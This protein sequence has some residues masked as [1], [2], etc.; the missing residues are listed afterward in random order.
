[1]NLDRR[2]ISHELHVHLYGCLTPQDVWELGRDL[3]RQRHERLNAYA[4]RYEG[5]FGIR[6]DFESYWA[7]ELGLANI[8][9]DFLCTTP[10]S[11]EQFETKFSLPIA[12]FPV[13]HARDD[14][15]VL[16]HVMERHRS[17]GLVH[18]EYRFVYPPATPLTLGYSLK[19]HLD[20]LCQVMAEFKAESCGIFESRLALSL[21]RVP[22]LGMR[23]YLA[24]KAWQEAS[25]AELKC[26]L[27]AIDFSGYEE[28]TAAEGIYQICGRLH[29]DNARAPGDALALLIHAGETTETIPVSEGIRRVEM[30][31]RMG[32]HRIGHAVALGADCDDETRAMQG[33]VGRWI[34]DET[35]SVIECCITSNMVLAGVRD[36]LA[37]PVKRFVAEGLRVC[38][39]TDDPGI[40]GID[41]KSEYAKAVQVL[42]P[43]EALRI[44]DATPNYHSDVLSGRA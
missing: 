26:F 28:T 14:L 34:A 25:P 11:F 30:A 10:S 1:M 27:S 19:Q 36:L 17:Q 40:F 41:S 20:G 15:Q 42:G 7:D 18:V 37:H 16:R 31:A 29:A 35:K 33:R 23:Q 3:W 4:E 12:L 2:Q 24:V 8:A 43:E 38:L 21:S 32:A 22:D 39:A 6:P 9:R 44:I 13:S 5:A